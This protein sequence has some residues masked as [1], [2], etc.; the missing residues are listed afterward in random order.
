MTVL[1][2]GSGVVGNLAAAYF[3]RYFPSLQVKVVGRRQPDLPIVGE[4]LVELSTHFIRDLGLSEYLIEQHLPKYGLT[5]YYKLHPDR[6]EDLTYV[7]DE[8]P[9]NPPF[10]S[11]LI[12]RFSFDRD[13]QALNQSRGV[14]YIE[15]RVTDVALGG[16]TEH[17]ITVKRPDGTEEALTARWLIDATGRTRLLARKLGLEQPAPHQ[18]SVFWFRLVD[19]DATILNRMEALKKVNRSFD[20]YYC[21]HHFFGRGNWIWLIPIRSEDS[22]KM[23][24]VGLTFRPD[25]FPGDVT[26]RHEFLNWVTQE[27]PVIRDFVESGEVIDTNVYRNYMYRTRQRYSSGR[28]FL[29]GDAADTVDPLYST[30]LALASLAIQQVGAI[31]QRDLQGTLSE[32]FVQDLDDCYGGLHATSNGLVSQLYEVMHDAYQCHLR[33]NLNV[34]ATFHVA[35]PLI[36]NGYFTDPVGAPLAAKLARPEGMMRHLKA[37]D[38]LITEAGEELPELLPRHFSRVQSAFTLNYPYFEYLRDEDIPV[39]ISQLFWHMVRLRLQLFRIRG[40]RSLF[41][42]GQLGALLVTLAW[43]PILRAF[44]GNS[45]RASRM[46]R[47]FVSR[48]AATVLPLT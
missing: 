1:I 29:I 9:A 26:N 13:L 12:N 18:R 16:E 20:S 45:L 42:W 37:F 4:S 41:N 33:M 6:P 36:M 10:P 27:H 43:V 11:F 46:V 15:G 35:I 17:R 47:W 34:A 38:P 40:I 28:W 30:G 31:I 24:S 22:R 2:M 8:S 5:F 3:N 19:F 23:I 7:V 21:T 25:L 39:S 32:A 48:R 44:K 14:D